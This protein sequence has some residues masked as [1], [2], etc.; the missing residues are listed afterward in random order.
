VQALF[1]LWIPASTALFAL[2][3][4]LGA[5]AARTLVLAIFLALVESS[6]AKLRFFRLPQFLS[7]GFLSAFLAVALRLL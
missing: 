3:L 1:L 2:A 7:I 4:G 5:F 6:Y